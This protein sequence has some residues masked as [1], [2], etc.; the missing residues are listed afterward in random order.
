MSKLFQISN[1]LKNS[2]H[3]YH[4]R[5]FSSIS[6]FSGARRGPFT[7]LAPTLGN[8]YDDDPFLRESLQIEIPAEYL[9][10]IDADLRQFGHRVATD[11]Y[12]LHL[13]CERVQPHLQMY[14]AWGE[15]VDNLIVCDAWKQMKNIAAKEGLISIAYGNE[16]RKYSVYSRI[17]QMSK[18]YLYGPSSGL[19]GCPLA[20]TD[21]AAKTIEVKIKTNFL[22]KK[23]IF[24]F[25]YNNL[26]DT[27]RSK[28]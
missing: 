13:E 10:E 16:R 17:Y 5:F 6:K 15:R 14:D 12:K 3:H 25:N 26:K 22:K 9:G 24:L 20:M 11:I 19:F 28:F 21:G 8:Q 4:N 1:N 18:L 7:Q 2:H 27:W 23:R